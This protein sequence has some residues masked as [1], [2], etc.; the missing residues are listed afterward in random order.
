MDEIFKSNTFLIV[1]IVLD[2]LFLSLI[3]SNLFPI[4]ATAP[5]VGFV[6]LVL[7]PALAYT[8]VRVLRGRPQETAS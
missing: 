3:N 5:V 4:R 8:A 6:L 2:V 7:S 1:T